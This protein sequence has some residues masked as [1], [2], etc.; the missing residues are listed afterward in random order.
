MTVAPGDVPGA[1]V[2][3]AAGGAPGAGTHRRRVVVSGGASGIGEA[4]VRRL[5]AA[6][7]EVVIVDRNAEGGARVAADTGATMAV[8]NVAASSEVDVAV[9][10]AVAVMGGIDGVVACAGVGLL[11]RLEDVTDRE[12]DRIVSV[13]LTGTFHVL[14]AAHRHLVASEAASV[15]TVASVSGVRPTRG[16]GPY[17]AAKAA[18]VALTQSAAL[19]WAPSIRVNCVSPG[20]VVTPLNSVIADDPTMRS[21]VEA[22]TPLARLG[23][24]DEVASA[25]EFLLGPESSYLTGQNLIIDG[26][27]ML[28]SQQV[29]DLL[30][31]LLRPRG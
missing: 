30:A 20:F 15:V 8:A 18:V 19:E 7:D 4:V 31:R 1:E 9:A 28:G 27:S 16:E 11:K 10:H 13:N 6:G 25:I 12:F 22:G 26:G 29:D 24:A 21:E 5:R 23:D 2:G 14:R 17:S 3:G